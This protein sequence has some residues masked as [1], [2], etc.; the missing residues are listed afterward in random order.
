MPREVKVYRVAGYMY[1]YRSGERRKFVIEVPA[2]RPEHAV[3]RVLSE[4]GSRHKLSRAHIK[5]VEVVEI[6]ENEVSTPH[7]AELLR[8]ER[9]VVAR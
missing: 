7:V 8:L 2:I 6:P 1:L 9:L 5:L 4:L 3:E